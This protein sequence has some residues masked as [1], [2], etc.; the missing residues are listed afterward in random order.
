M[1]PSGR[2]KWLTVSTT[3][4]YLIEC[5]ELAPGTDLLGALTARAEDLRAGGWEL[6]FDCLSGRFS[7]N[8]A[9]ECIHVRLHA[10]PP[11]PAPCDLSV[12]FSS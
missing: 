7:A 2:T 12:P 5:Y 9:A 6:D 8:R 1:A 4:G 3:A 10:A 11:S